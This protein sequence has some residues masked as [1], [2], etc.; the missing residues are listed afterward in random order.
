MHRRAGTHTND[1]CGHGPRISS[2]PQ[3]RCAASGERASRRV[4]F[5][6]ARSR[7]NGLLMKVDG[8]HIRGIW[9]EPDGHTV[10]AI[11]QRRLP[12]HF[13]VAQLTSC[14]TAAD[15]I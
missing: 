12:H 9:L 8:R 4:S 2:A 5:R 10:S 7:I 1:A 13:M 15:A 6:E 3:E 11:D 14:D